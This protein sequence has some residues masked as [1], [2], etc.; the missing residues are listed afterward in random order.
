MKTTLYYPI[1]VTLLIVMSSCSGGG[2]TAQIPPTIDT[3]NS[4]KG[5]V[6]K[7][8]IEGA[9]IELVYF[10]SSGNEIEITA[11]NAP[12]IT[13]STGGYS[14]QVDGRTLMGINSPLIV[15]S[16]GGAM[17]GGSAPTLEAIIED[18]LPLAFSQVTITCDLSTASS[19]AAGL[20]RNLAQSA[21][22]A[23]DQDDIQWFIAL[24]EDQ[25]NV[26]LSDD[27]RDSGTSLAMF[28]HSVDQN[29]DLISTSANNPAVDELISYFI[30][31]L[32]SSSGILDGT[33]DSPGS[34]GIDTTA[35]FGTGPLNSLVPAGPEGFVFMVLSSDR[36]YIEDS[37]RDEASVT[38]LMFNA[39]GHPLQDLQ[40]VL[41]GMLSGPGNLVLLDRDYQLGEIRASLTASASGDNL[42]RSVY[43]LSNGNDITGN[44]TVPSLDLITDTDS[45]GFSD[46]EERMGWRVAVDDLGYGDAYLIIYNVTSDPG[47][48]DTDGDGLDDL[49]EYLIRTDPRN[50]D[51]DGDGL[52]D[53][54]EWNRW[55]T[56]PNSVDTDADCRGPDRD[57]PPNQNLFDGSEL[58]VQRTSP[59]L[60][61]TDG[62]GKT[63]FEEVD[64]PFRSP[65][66]AD[67]PELQVEVVDAMDIR[68]DVQYAEEEGK[69]HQYGTEFTSSTTT[70]DSTYNENSVNASLTVGNESEVGLFK[71]GSKWK[72]ELTVGYGQVWST[73][74]ETSNTSQ[75]SHSDYSTDSRTRTETTAAGSMTTGIRITNTGGLTFTL[76][77]I[78]ITVRQWQ[79]GRNPQDPEAAGVFKTLATLIPPISGGITLAPGDATPVLQVEATDLNASRVKEFLAKPSSLYIEP[80]FYELEN[81]EGLNFDYLEE[82]TGTRTARLTIDYG[83]GSVE[84]YRVATNVDRDMD[85]SL[86]GVSLGVVMEQILG[87]PYET[88]NRQDLLPGSATNE[89]ILH[90]IRNVQTADDPERGFWMVILESDNPPADNL[91][92]DQIPLK[93][94]DRVRLIYAIDSDGDGLYA[95]EE[96]HYRT[97][98]GG[99]GG[100]TDGDGLTDRDEVRGETFVNVS[101]NRIDCGWVVSVE[102]LDPY[103]VFADPASPDQDNDGVNDLAEKTAGTDPVLPDTDQDGIMDGRDPYPLRPARVLHVAKGDQT[104]FDGNSWASAYSS[105]QSALADAAG[106][107]ASADSG[108]D[109]SEIWVARGTYTPDASEPSV[110]F[111]M[112]DLLG[113]Y[114]GFNGDESK[115]SAR[116]ADPVTNGTYLSG[117]LGVDDLAG[118]VNGSNSDQIVRGNA[119]GTDSI[120]DGFIITGAVSSGMVVTNGSPTLRNLFFWNNSGF[121]GGALIIDG[122]STPDGMTISNC[123]FYNNQAFYY[124]GAIYVRNSSLLI[125]ASVFSANS[126]TGASVSFGGAVYAF[127]GLGG[128]THILRFTNSDILRNQASKGGGIYVNQGR[129]EM[130]KCRVEENRAFGDFGGYQA[131]GGGLLVYYTDLFLSQ[132]VFWKNTAFYVPGSGDTASRGLEGGGVFIRTDADNTV[133]ILNCTFNRNEAV[134]GGGIHSQSDQMII[135]NSLFVNNTGRGFS[136]LPVTNDLDQ[137]FTTWPGSINVQ[138]SCLQNLDTYRGWG[139]VDGDDS[140]FVD[141]ARGDLRLMEGAISI[142]SGSNLVD[143]D[144]FTSGFQTPPETDLAGKWRIT[145][146]DL[147][148]EEVIDIGAYEFQ[149]I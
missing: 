136:S 6:V 134:G 33:M 18:P 97:E 60:Q 31:N 123:I 69:S 111:N 96:Q 127:L 95:A 58:G 119:V 20:L 138:N 71:T 15:R 121:N 66:I 34:P 104:V 85:G 122:Q 40:S 62:D 27:P 105:L 41:M 3:T 23:P 26:K 76:T 12:V 39:E 44:I 47:L 70:S 99:T 78:G 19:I 10:D 132:S 81:A 130:D 109:V 137:I 126:A 114:G 83:K 28:N 89:R 102:G 107:N 38:T 129:M 101:G 131:G 90:R 74:T 64:H 43:R 14:F 5:S 8:P 55:L 36:E 51:T 112:V 37:G 82:I 56:N 147:D 21:G 16:S 79:P 29:L 139:N 84:N 128:E 117:D 42:V 30:S 25:F 140:Q 80:A 108:D 24:V 143:F 17:Y 72:A 2:G 88:R 86:V 120:L 103:P 73:T 106:S 77:D 148:G 11:E 145:D 93:A 100:D 67:L 4:I 68:L 94:G 7:G 35:N 115:R 113:I 9:E 48:A 46:D 118:Q 45:D 61:D 91:N 144:P 13:D 54:E 133:Q 32:S 116:D 1:G 135:H 92:F 65:L 141:P 87:I 98:D 22:S 52:T 49:L 110:S 124:G 142:D 57:R 149:G 75:S 63:D 146:G 59:T 125:D 53:E 50:V